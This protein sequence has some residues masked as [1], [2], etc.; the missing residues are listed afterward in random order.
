MI[1]FATPTPKSFSDKGSQKLPKTEV[2]LLGI[3]ILTKIELQKEWWLLLIKFRIKPI[4][5][6]IENIKKC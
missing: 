1:S 2:R 5:N 4:I 3:Q 6:N